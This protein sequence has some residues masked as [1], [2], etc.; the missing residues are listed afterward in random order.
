M[1]HRKEAGGSGQKKARSPPSGAKQATTTKTSPSDDTVAK[2]ALHTAV[3]AHGVGSSKATATTT[4]SSNSTDA[5]DSG[6]HANS[7][8]SPVEDEPV[9]EIS[10]E[11]EEKEENVSRKKTKQG[12]GKQG[13]TQSKVTTT[14]SAAGTSKDQSSS[15]AADDS[16]GDHLPSCACFETDG[17]SGRCREK[18]QWSCVVCSPKGPFTMTF[19]EADACERSHAQVPTAQIIADNH[20]RLLKSGQVR[21][22]KLQ[23]WEQKG[24]RERI[25]ETTSLGRDI[26]AS[27]FRSRFERCRQQWELV[28]QHRKVV[29]VLMWSRMLVLHREYIHTLHCTALLCFFLFLPLTRFLCVCL[30]RAVCCICRTKRLPPS[31]VHLGSLLT[32]PSCKT[33]HLKLRGSPPRPTK[34]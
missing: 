30:L 17:P 23:A 5:D 33:L 3:R 34:P 26:S 27:G 4:A 31:L 29:C 14:A 7:P 2:S 24:V 16:R 21:W 20:V 10:D 13:D 15:K 12:K 9:V 18:E 28:A 6:S 22:D 25:R 11:E 8:G 1:K 32:T 19:A